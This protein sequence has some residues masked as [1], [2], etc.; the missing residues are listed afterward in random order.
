MLVS[1]SLAAACSGSSAPALPEAAVEE[2]APPAASGEQESG[3]QV[4]ETSAA[5]ASGE[6]SDN[7]DSATSAAA[8]SSAGATEANDEAEFLDAGPVPV[9]SLVAS[10]SIATAGTV[11]RVQA[12][13]SPASGLVL[14]GVDGIE[15]EADWQGDQASVTLPESLQEGRYVLQL[16]EGGAFTTIEVVNVAGLRMRVDRAHPRDGDRVVVTIESGI[17]TEGLLG[18]LM[19]E[20]PAGEA[21][22]L[23]TEVFLSATSSGLLAPIEPRPLADFLG[24]PLHLPEG[25][26]GTLRLL[27]FKADG[28][29]GDD[30]D[31]SAD[32]GAALDLGADYVS[33]AV[34]VERCNSRATVSGTKGGPALVR[35]FWAEGSLRTAAESVD[36]TFSFSTGAGAVVVMITPGDFASG[37][38]ETE[39]LVAEVPC[40]GRV[41]LSTQVSAFAPASGGSAGAETHLASGRPVSAPQRLVAVSRGSTT[42]PCRSV[43]VARVTQTP[44]NLEWD[45]HVAG[46]LHGFL[47]N[48]SV[49]S[50]SDLRRATEFERLRQLL[51]ADDGEFLEAIEASMDTDFV[52]VG[53]FGESGGGAAGRLSALAN[54]ATD[55]SV[56]VSRSG[57]DIASVY[58]RQLLPDFGRAMQSAAICG[59]VTPES[60]GLNAGDEQ[61]LTYEVLDLGGNPASGASV[62]IDE[63]RLGSLDPSDGSVED[64]AFRTTYTARDNVRGPDGFP[65]RAEW[66]GPAGA[67]RTADDESRTVMYI[68]SEWRLRM[69]LDNAA[70]GGSSDEFLRFAWDGT[71][72]VNEPGALEGSGTGTLTGAGYCE[73][74]GIRVEGPFEYGATFSFGIGGEQTEFD[75]GDFVFGLTGDAWS[76]RLP[77]PSS[78]GDCLLLEGLFAAFGGEL[79]K[80]IA[81]QPQLLSNEG[82]IRTAAGAGGT[83]IEMPDG[84]TLQ[85]TITAAND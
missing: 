25:S 19:V 39:T 75:G 33:N 71:F 52:V 58:L 46:S 61:E 66:D 23:A 34:R 4:E 67:V 51:G 14:I 76:L 74:N 78:N 42:E 54:R 60:A 2:A 82:A 40:G 70:A 12:D 50:L 72:R 16:A 21:G 77:A 56:Q 48:A 17:D 18:L 45:L 37:F 7:S 5:A 36:G 10:P 64:D 38:G 80:L 49:I 9:L 13:G 79:L 69:D 73:V 85:I 6:G 83:A 41:T 57:S 11:I 24:R 62:S 65:I 81:H 53:Q 28:S 27:A 44:E 59:S 20:T 31:L 68:G 35:A 84:S 22:G 55:Q 32:E 47:P 3:A 8:A 29:T 30:A 43:F 63:P 15:A 1:L 26:E